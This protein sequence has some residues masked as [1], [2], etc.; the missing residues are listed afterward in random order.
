[1][2]L[3][4]LSGALLGPS[5]AGAQTAVSTWHN[6][7]ARTGANMQE[8]VL[9]PSN[10]NS[11]G[12]GKRCAYPV[13]GQIYAQPLYIPRLRIGGATHNVV[14][15][16]TE[17]DSVYAFDADCSQTV[18]LWHTSFLGAKITSMPCTKDSQ[19]QCDITIIAPEHGITATPAIDPFS[20]TIYIGA[21]S[22]E[23]G[24][25][26]QK[27]HALAITTGTERPGSP[28]IIAGAAPNHPATKFDSQ[29]AF[30]R[31]GL[32]LLNGTVIFPFASNDSS[33]GW[34]FG[35]DAKTLAKTA[36]FCVTPH[37]QLGGIWG[38]G[39]APAVDAASN[40]YAATG[41][42]TFDAA[43]GGAD[44]GMSALRMMPSGNTYEVTGFFTPSAESRLSSRDLD[45]DSGG[46][47]LLPDQPGPH[48]HE[49]V[50]GFK[51]G[52]LFLLNRDNL[53]G[54]GTAH[55]LQSFVTDKSGYW[56][57]AAYWNGNVYIAGVGGALTQW[58]L[59]NGAFPPSPTRQSRTTYPY[60]GATP[61]IS[62]N[63][64][65][66]GIVWTIEA[67]G[68]VRGGKP[69]ILRAHAA[70]D[71]SH[72]LYNSTQAGTRD[73]AGPS[74]KFTVPTVADGK[75]FV[76]TQTELDIYGLLGN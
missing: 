13:D 4:M 66:N 69:A 21:Q 53:G 57:S 19:P 8:T 28:A 75:V 22:V 10:V 16:A 30:Q 47:V 73:A 41:N 33:Y 58:H 48:A 46:L 11:N 63:G 7:L 38:G 9:T 14:F 37:G 67:Q 54:F 50:I 15:A 71:V 49:A 25:Y 56:S 5:L 61:S 23:S 29:Q 62:A 6:D 60:P 2:R 64:T 35:Y 74:V 32:L 51:T 31:A 65:T 52:R 3:I 45:L 76:G 34:L 59:S 68:S 39:A 27:L 44:Y 12:F 72:E 40:I 24:V 43:S 17:H 26:T 55:A 36:I 70:S 1:M 18:P 20:N 42:G